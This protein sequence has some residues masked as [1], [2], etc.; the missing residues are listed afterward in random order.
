MAITLKSPSE[1]AIM[2]KANEIV[3]KALN[4]VEKNIKPGISTYELDSICEATIR[5]NGG[6]PTFK[7]YKG[8]PSALCIS[9][10]EE[11]VHG[12]PSKKRRIKDGD[13][14]S[15]D[16]GCRFEGLCGDSARTIPVGK[17]SEKVQKLLEVTEQCLYA[18]IDNCRAG[19][20]LGDVSNAIQTLAEEHGY[21]IVIDFVGHGI[22]RSPHEEP[23]VSNMG[24]KS[25][26]ILL[27][28][29]LV[30]AIEPMVNL[31]TGN[32]KVL[33]DKWTV[34]T[35]DRKLSAHFEHSVA[36]TDGDPI[37]LS[38]NIFK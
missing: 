2:K 15:I 7:G 13:I 8:F 34:V 32:V 6:D 23:Q 4:A 38:E 27:Q 11:V 22:G 14:V 3:V 1:I 31:G 29:G 30:I 19:K 25:S 20:R 17:V 16:T 18:A 26:G 21:G 12:I 10:N 24:E 35:K 37:V 5:E 28:P 9:L 33:N 36:V